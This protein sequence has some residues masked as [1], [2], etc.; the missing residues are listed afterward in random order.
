MI[1]ALRRLRQENRKSERLDWAELQDLISRKKK[2][3]SKR[4]GKGGRYSRRE[5]GR[6]GKRELGKGG[7]KGH[8]K[9]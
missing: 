1:P 6:Q 3:G 7:G 4:E 8:K 9:F 5:G 2:E